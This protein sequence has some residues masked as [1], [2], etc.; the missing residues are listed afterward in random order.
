MR[1]SPYIVLILGLLAIRPTGCWAEDTS[2]DTRTDQVDRVKKKRYANPYGL[3]SD[4]YYGE[5]HLLGAS[6][7]GAFGSMFG[8]SDYTT[9]GLGWNGTLDFVYEYQHNYLLIQTG[10][11]IRLDNMANQLKDYDLEKEMADDKNRKYI[12]R[13]EFTN[14][15]EKYSLFSLQIPALVGAHYHHFYGLAGVNFCLPLSAVAQLSATCTTTGY[16]P[17]FDVPFEEMDNH[18]LRKDVPIGVNNQTFKVNF[19][20]LAHIELGYDYGVFEKRTSGYQRKRQKDLRY[21]IAAFADCGLIPMGK[22]SSLP[23]IVIPEQYPY[24]FEMF[25][26]TNLLNSSV[27]KEAQIHRFSVGLRFTFLF[28][29]AYKPPCNTCK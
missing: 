26:L 3:R 15:T 25:Q 8:N 27:N 1:F 28:G 17:Q 11:G 29:F 23:V 7:K 4:Q 5:H 10:F 16:Y 14:R 12:L 2:S 22:A 24:D 20:V 18:G 9:P 13:Y 21:R 6:I 19:D